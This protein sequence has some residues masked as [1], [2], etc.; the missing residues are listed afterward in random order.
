MTSRSRAWLA[1]HAKQ[2]FRPRSW[3]RH[4]NSCPTAAATAAATLQV[5]NIAAVY[6]F[7]STKTAGCVCVC[8]Q[9]KAFTSSPHAPVA[10]A[11]SG[12]MAQPGNSRVVFCHVVYMNGHDVVACRCS[13]QAAAAFGAVRRPWRLADTEMTLLRVIKL[14]RVQTMYGQVFHVQ[15]LQTTSRCESW[16]CAPARGAT[17]WPRRWRRG[18]TSF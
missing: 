1:A 4:P 5:R 11:A 13:R 17:W 14:Y 15:T 7:C 8:Q 16:R 9:V 3:W 10:H 6:F 18:R 12:K 2:G